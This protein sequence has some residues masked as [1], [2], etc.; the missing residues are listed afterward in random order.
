MNNYVVK[1][2]TILGAAIIIA[3]AV[4]I[5]FS[6]YQTCKRE[7]EARSPDRAAGVVCAPHLR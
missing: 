7:V 3:V 5:Y 6:P 1:A 2:A 4:N